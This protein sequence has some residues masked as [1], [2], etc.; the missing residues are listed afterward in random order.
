MRCFQKR[1]QKGISAM[2]N[3]SIF[4]VILKIKAGPTSH[5]IIKVPWKVAGNHTHTGW[6][7]GNGIRGLSA[8]VLISVYKI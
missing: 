3:S 1:M 7:Q 2:H 4:E 5:Y 6:C 8:G